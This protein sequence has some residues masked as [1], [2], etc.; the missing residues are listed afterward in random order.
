MIQSIGES[1][2]KIFRA[3]ETHGELSISQ[4]KNLA[5]PDGFRLNAA[6]GWLAREDKL[7]ITL[8]GKTIKIR[9]R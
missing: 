2:G 7:L 8:S 3:L 4:L 1:A 5:E 9:L 6:I